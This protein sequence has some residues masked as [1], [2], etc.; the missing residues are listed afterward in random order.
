MG[1]FIRNSKLREQMASIIQNRP[2]PQQTKPD[3]AA[4]LARPM[5]VKAG[6]R[7]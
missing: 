1:E 5:A 3:V 6:I 7:I 4:V 2:K